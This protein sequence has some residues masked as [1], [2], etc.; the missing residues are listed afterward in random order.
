MTVPLFP[1]FVIT[2]YWD[3]LDLCLCFKECEWGTGFQTSSPQFAHLCFAVKRMYTF[4][5]SRQ[6]CA[7][8]F[9]T[10]GKPF[11]KCFK[12]SRSL[13]DCWDIG[14]MNISGRLKIQWQVLFLVSFIFRLVGMVNY[15]YHWRSNH[16]QMVQNSFLNLTFL[17]VVP[18]L[19]HTIEPSQ[20]AANNHNRERHSH[21]L[22]VSVTESLQ[23]SNYWT[24]WWQMMSV[25]HSITPQ[26]FFLH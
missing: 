25:L 8:G 14:V 13:W 9:I 1:F 12:S 20:G 15:P 18:S 11:S 26:V 2:S 4:L 7:E 16:L 10:L 21:S 24:P 3:V 23:W 5:H 19:T 22:L 17:L 6:V